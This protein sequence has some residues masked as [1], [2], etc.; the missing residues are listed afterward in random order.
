MKKVY[1]VA[2]THWDFEWYFTRQEAR[3]QFIFHMDEVL[4]ALES[5]QLD[6]YTLDGQ[7]SIVEDYLSLFPERE[8]QLKKFVQAGRLFVGP[9]FTQIDE[10]TT[11]GESIV[12]NLRIGIREA[13]E[14]GS[15]MRIGY[16]PDSFGQSQDM[17][18]IYHGFDIQ[19]ALFWRGMPNEANTRYFYWSSND[20]SKVL[21]ANI[22]NGYYAGVDLVEKNDFSDLVERISTHTNSNAHL[23]PVGG[24]QRA[25]DF[26][27]K[28]RIDKANQEIEESTV[29]IESNYPQFF[30]A[31]EKDA[32]EFL[33][34]KGEF[35]EPID[36]KIHR[37]IY[38]SRYDLKQ[39]YDQLERLL[40][41]QLEPMSVLAA[42]YGIPVKQGLIDS[43]WKIVSRGQAHDSAGG[44]NSDKT[45]RDIY[46]RGINGLQEAQSCM[47]YLLRKLSIS[48]NRNQED[49]LFMWNPLP[50][51]L[52]VI[53]KVK[54]STQNKH[55]SLTDDRGEKVAFE[56]IEQVMEN[57]ALL[58]RNPEEMLDES[59]YVSTIAV[60]CTLPAMGY[61]H[62]HVS[63][64]EEKA[65]TL[66]KATRIENDF[67]QI[68]FTEGKFNLCLKKNGKKY[69]DFLSFEDGGDEGD[70]YDYSPAFAD[71]ILNLNFN[72]SQTSHVEQGKLL[73][74]IIVE[75]EWKLPYNLASRKE[76]QLDGQVTYILTLELNKQDNRIQLR[77]NVN[78]QVLDHRLRLVLKTDVQS[79]FSTSDTPFGIINR[80][81]EEKH[82]QDWRARGYKEEP[83]SM[84]PMI[85]FA[86]L[87][88]TK[89]SWSFLSKGT[90]DFQVL[91]KE[92]QELAITIFRGVGYLG[93][94]DTQRR[95]GDAS[96]LQNREVE[97]PDSQLLGEVFFE[98]NIVIDTD[99]NAA[100]LQNQYLL[101][102]QENIYYQTQTI[103]RF[104]TPIEYFPINKKKLE[105]KE[106]QVIALANSEVAFSSME[107]CIDQRGIQ[108]RL[109]NPCDT[110][111]DMPGIIKL[112]DPATIKLLNLEGKIIGNLE[113]SAEELIMEEFR[114]GE[115]RTYGIFFKK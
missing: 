24:D 23:L 97:T 11:S 93:R 107:T 90:K 102:T 85:H 45:N 57:A 69:L 37:G 89:T 26:N 73:S 110:A 8:K 22:K 50:F 48:L 78:N 101:T 113:D 68:E 38:S 58:R 83:T 13:E 56:I 46:M 66:L 87:H 36:S 81:I 82:L 91:N 15:A 108:L 27:L 43:L 18:K 29:F 86:N 10:M 74:R 75:G 80:P 5:N 1:T 41:Y 105:L 30:K 44:C 98:G 62:Y 60:E 52:K 67:Y 16:L 28:T 12:R 4:E 96:G 100:A 65:Q 104:S 79:E 114:P 21:T 3:V 71:W 39:V 95:P 88:D 76:R 54:L 14:L 63:A 19:H 61:V 106:Q 31:L 32:Q 35:I 20:G 40:T 72:N 115:I 49:S 17:P 112:Q 103:N 109:Y 84:R 51:E 25:V 59:Y 64:E 99:F 6:F 92:Q 34:I 42:R 70:T 111:Q 77:L 47:D 2:H 55:F 53:K 7:M 9:W 33:D 94:P